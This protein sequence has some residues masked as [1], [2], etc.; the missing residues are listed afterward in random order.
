[1]GGLCVANGNAD[2]YKL[3]AACKPSSAPLG[4]AAFGLHDGVDQAGPK[5]K[6]NGPLLPAFPYLGTPRPGAK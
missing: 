2:T 3:G 5:V 6:A 1:M 4:T